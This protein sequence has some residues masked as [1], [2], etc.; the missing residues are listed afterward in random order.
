VEAIGRSFAGGIALESGSFSVSATHGSA[1]RF[2]GFALYSDGDTEILRWGV[3]T[4][5]ADEGTYAG[6]W[7]AIGTGGQTL[8]SPIARIYDT[9]P[10]NADYTVSWSLLSGG[11]GM[12]I[13]LTIG[14]DSY[15]GENP[16][17]LTLPDASAVTA[18]AALAAGI[19]QSESL[20]FDNLVVAGQAVPEPSTL[21]LLVL[22][23]PSLFSFRR[24]RRK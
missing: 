15:S 4:A 22:S 21:A 23:V 19:S 20:R 2:S 3:T 24:R 10:V 8:Y 17:R 18:I 12:E 16:F 6:F 1:D 5:E 9:A 11:A 14:S 7:Y 13:D